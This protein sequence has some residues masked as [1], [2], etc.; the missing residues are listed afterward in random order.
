[1]TKEGTAT[2]RSLGDLYNGMRGGS[3]KLNPDFQRKLV[4]NDRHKE[5]FIDTILKKYP[6]PEVYFC[7]GDTDL[8]LKKTI[9]LVVDGQQ[10]LSTI[11]SYIE[12]K[13]SNLKNITSY[14]ELTD[15]E[16]K[17]FLEYPVV[18]RDLGKANDKDIKEIFRRIN[19]VNYALNATEIRHALY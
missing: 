7:N 18:V 10:R 17:D 5:A 19:S 15:D 3:I 14:E 6:F 12:G 4:W 13:L 2:N 1:M 16:K 9:K 11:Y 8:K